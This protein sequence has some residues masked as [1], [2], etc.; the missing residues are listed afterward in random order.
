MPVNWAF[1]AAQ[2]EPESFLAVQGLGLSL[3]R[4]YLDAAR[5]RSCRIFSALELILGSTAFTNAFTAA[6]KLSN[7]WQS[8]RSLTTSAGGVY[9]MKLLWCAELALALAFT[10]LSAFAIE[11][12]SIHG[13]VTD[14]LGAAV[15]GAQVELFRRARQLLTSTTDTEGKY[16]FSPLAPGRYQVRTQAPSFASQESDAVYVGSGSNVAVDL[17]LKIGSVTQEIVV[18]ATG[19]KLPETQTG[20]SISVVTSDQFQYKPEVLETLRQV[21]GVQILE[22]G[23]RGIN[24]SLFI[25][26]GESKANKVLLDGIPL[27]EI[28]GAVDFGG[29]FTT[30]NRSD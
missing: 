3:L 15:R 30:G 26:G 23:Q 11:G 25:R 22:N 6:G 10:T 28:G 24:E 5:F 8:G 18:S 12:S 21:P 19:T 29:V 13:T 7:F 2:G 20:S 1:P 27:N 17:T 16:R 14:P 4:E 9:M